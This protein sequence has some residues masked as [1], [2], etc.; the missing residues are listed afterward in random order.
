MKKER[1]FTIFFHGYFTFQSIAVQEKMSMFLEKGLQAN[2]QPDM[3]LHATE[4]IFSNKLLSI[5]NNKC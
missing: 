4:K 3:L 1:H 5:I 2:K